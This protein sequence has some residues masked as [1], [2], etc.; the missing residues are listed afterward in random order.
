[1]TET[2]PSRVHQRRIADRADPEEGLRE[3]QRG[4]PEAPSSGR[5]VTVQRAAAQPSV[6]LGGSGYSLSNFRGRG[7]GTGA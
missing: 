3:K 1:M 5:E 6:A 2:W 4:S 7:W